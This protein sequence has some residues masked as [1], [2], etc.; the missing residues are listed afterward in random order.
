MTN[1]IPIT[2]EQF[3]SMYKGPSTLSPEMNA[4]CS[5]A[6][7]EG[8]SFSCRWKHARRS[9]TSRVNISVTGKRLHRKFS[10]TCKDKVVYVW[11]HEG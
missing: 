4:V 2:K 1:I 11:R 6:E 3:F 8:V 9:C 5:L 7:G 10:V